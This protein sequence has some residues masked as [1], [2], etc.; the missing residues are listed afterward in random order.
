MTLRFGRGAAAPSLHRASGRRAR[1]IKRFSLGAAAVLALAACGSSGTSPI[2][3]P[4]EYTLIQA[5]DSIALPY[6]Q[7]V[8]I[9]DAFLAFTG[10]RDDSRCPRG[11]TCVWEGDATAGITVHP[12]CYKD[13]CRAASVSLDLHTNR[14][15]RSGEAWGVR[16]QLLALTPEPQAGTTPEPRSYVAWVR[17]TPAAK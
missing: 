4:I 3:T 6:R 13:G 17:V 1:A 16:V 11:V 10:A 7:D 5:A 14:E 12:G 8:K 15:P 9:G 2:T